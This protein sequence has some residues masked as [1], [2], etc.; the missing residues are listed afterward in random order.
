MPGEPLHLRLGGEQGAVHVGAEL[1]AQRARGA[2]GP[3]PVGEVE[4]GRERGRVLLGVAHAPGPGT[5]GGPARRVHPDALGGARVV[6][7]DAAQLDLGAGERAEVHDRHG[8]GHRVAVHGVH[9]EAQAGQGHGVTADAAAQIRHRGDTGATEAL[10]VQGRH[11]EARGLLEAVRGE[12]HRI[13]ELA[14]LLAGPGPQPGLREHRRDQVGRVAGLPQRGAAA[15]RIGLLVGRQGIQQRETAGVQH[16]LDRA[17]GGGVVSQR[18]GHAS[19]T[20]RCTSRGARRIRNAR[21]PRACRGCG[22]PRAGD[23][24]RRSGTAA[25]PGRPRAGRRPSAYRGRG[26]PA[27]RGR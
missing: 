26:G 24:P 7:L 23:A 20:T 2:V 16:R 25:A 22:R 1:G 15:Q 12:E 19:E 14:E 6:V 8:D 11:R 4:H 3:E 13:R 9:V 27:G 5:G 18:C 21:P 17:G 10:G